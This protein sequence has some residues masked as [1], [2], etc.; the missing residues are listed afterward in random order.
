M[1]KEEVQVLVLSIDGVVDFKGYMI[2]F[3]VY[4]MDLDDCI[5]YEI[6]ELDFS[7]DIDLR[8]ELL[9]FCFY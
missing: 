2:M 7:K 8:L 4:D 6:S 9:I 5:F 1:D 3:F